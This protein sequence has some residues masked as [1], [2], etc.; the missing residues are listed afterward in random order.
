M[1]AIAVSPVNTGT[2][3]DEECW[4]AV[5]ERNAGFDGVFVLGVR[6]TGI[7][8]APSRQKRRSPH[9]PAQAYALDTR[10]PQRHHRPGRSLIR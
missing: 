7:S 2:I 6:S 9:T 4:R 5:M 10:G 1:V 3:S 8:V